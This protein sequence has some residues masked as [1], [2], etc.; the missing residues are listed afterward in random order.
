M[1]KPICYNGPGCGCE[2]GKCRPPRPV[3]LNEL[4]LELVKI[5]AELS[6]LWEYVTPR[7]E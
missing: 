6:R 7:T 5:R 3:T 4:H 1:P 2:P